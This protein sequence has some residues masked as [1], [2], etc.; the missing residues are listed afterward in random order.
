MSILLFESFTRKM[1]D[2]RDKAFK[3]IHE[4]YTE[5]V[6]DFLHEITDKFTPVKF[7]VGSSSVFN[8]WFKVELKD[9]DTFFEVF[10]EDIFDRIKSEY[11]GTST[12]FKVGLK[13]RS[14]EAYPWTYFGSIG[15]LVNCDDK[16]IQMVYEYINEESESTDYSHFIICL[17][18]A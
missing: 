16:K 3:D 12:K 9:I 17:L 13:R 7:E 6:R 10:H 11:P 5:I 1:L 15:E 18:I 8:I 2:E 4:K 14:M